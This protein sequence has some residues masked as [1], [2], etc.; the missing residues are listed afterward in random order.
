LACSAAY[1]ATC[2]AGSAGAWVV[3]AAAGW[4]ATETPATV[5][6]ASGAGAATPSFCLRFYTIFSISAW[7]VLGGN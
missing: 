7:E 4:P 6:T 1:K 3:A 5:C 2:V